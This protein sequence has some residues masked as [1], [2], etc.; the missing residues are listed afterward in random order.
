VSQYFYIFAELNKIQKKKCTL[1][2]FFV[3]LKKVAAN[4][5]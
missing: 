2:S 3:F 1:I 4:L 5:A